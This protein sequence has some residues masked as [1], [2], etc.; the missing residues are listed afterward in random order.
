MGVVG[1]GEVGSDVVAVGVGVLGVG[2]GGSVVGVGVGEA[3]GVGVPLG[4]PGVDEGVGDADE[5]WADRDGCGVA[6]TCAT[7]ALPPSPA[8]CVAATGLCRGRTLG[9]ALRV[10][11][12]GTTAGRSS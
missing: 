3:G 11:A 2:V 7:L 8:M 4:E 9:A 10:A 6:A 5:W 1:A 12:G